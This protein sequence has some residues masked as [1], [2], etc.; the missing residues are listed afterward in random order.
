[1]YRPSADISDDGKYFLLSI[2]KDS[3]P[4]SKFYIGNLEAAGNAII[5][6]EYEWNKLIDDF[7][8]LYI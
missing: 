8:S 1:M 4:A 7:E 3:Y 2:R 6:Q 5:T